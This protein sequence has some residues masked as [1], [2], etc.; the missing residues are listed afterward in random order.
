M[1]LSKFYSTIIEEQVEICEAIMNVVAPYDLVMASKY[2]IP[3]YTAKSWICYLNPVK[4]NGIEWAFT[5]A[6]ELPQ[7]VQLLLDFKKR[8]QVGGITLYKVDQA[9]L[10]R[11]E[12]VLQEAIILDENEPYSSKRGKRK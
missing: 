8:K 7:E 6:N 4:K 2:E 9:L 1:N 3:F 11:G 10:E 5:R 12:V